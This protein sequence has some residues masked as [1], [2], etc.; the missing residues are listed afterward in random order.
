MSRPSLRSYGLLRP[1]VRP[2]NVQLSSKLSRVHFV[3]NASTQ[4]EARSTG[5]RFLSTT[6]LLGGGVALLAYYYDSRSILHEHVI[7]PVMRLVDP[8]TGHKL[9]VKMLSGSS[10]FRPSDRGVDGEKLQ[11]E[12]GLNGF[13]LARSYTR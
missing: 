8:E 4:P 2:A 13:D 12:V 7:M 3:R 9:A 5:R 1:L 6:L 10:W 11:A